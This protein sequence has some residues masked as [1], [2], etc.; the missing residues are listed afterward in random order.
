MS[1]SIPKTPTLQAPVSN[2]SVTHSRG[3]IIVIP[4]V[5]AVL[6]ILAA[7]LANSYWLSTLTS[8][9]AL[10]LAVTGVS[11]LYGQLGLVSLCQLALV[12]VGGW[13][14]LRIGH[15]GAPFEIS[16]ICGGIGAAGA[17]PAR[18]VSVIGD[19]DAGGRVFYRYQ[20]LGVS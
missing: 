20:C 15:S 9:V 12:G 7:L 19:I 11:I 16:L 14:T 6:T 1:S 18:A 17:A 8:A 4:L 10:A 3:Q 2:T 13:V 5:M